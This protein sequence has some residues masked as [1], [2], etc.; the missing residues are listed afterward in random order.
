MRW[1]VRWA[2]DPV[3]SLLSVARTDFRLATRLS[4]TVKAFGRGERVDLKK[5]A[6][7]RDA[8]R[9]RVGSWRIL[10]SIDGQEATVEGV[11]NRRDAY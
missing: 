2:Q 10:L 8:W 3:D 11:D 7:A 4:S 6:G 5:L 1:S 9:I